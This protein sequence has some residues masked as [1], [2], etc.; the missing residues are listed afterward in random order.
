MHTDKP[1]EYRIYVS[2]SEIL[3]A[4]KIVFLI[5]SDIIC[6]NIASSTILQTKKKIRYNINFILG[7][8]LK[9]GAIM[10]NITTPLPPKDHKTLTKSAIAILK[11]LNFPVKIITRTKM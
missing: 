3:N 6:L 11:S 8:S 7:N 1:F 9:A 10:V 5:F 4:I 2:F